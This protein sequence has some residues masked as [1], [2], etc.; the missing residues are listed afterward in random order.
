MKKLYKQ[1]RFILIFI[2]FAIG[3]QPATSQV[4]PWDWA[5]SP[6]GPCK[7]E[8]MTSVAAGNNGVYVTG[9]FDSAYLTFGTDTLFNSNPNEN[10]AFWARYDIDGNLLWAK[11]GEGL[12]DEDG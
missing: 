2:P 10:D 3:L 5:V 4:P 9:Y 6:S 1:L 12:F 8:Y 11:S 7:W